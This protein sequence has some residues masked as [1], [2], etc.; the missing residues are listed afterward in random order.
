M[1]FSVY[2]LECSDRTYYTGCTNNLE[3]RIR[4]HNTSQ[5]GA[6]YTKMRRPV[7]LLYSETFATLS[8]ARKREAKIKR[9]TKK[10]KTLLMNSP[11]S[12]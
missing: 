9:L 2:I 5:K 4:E 8:E 10:K 7:I 1:K 11:L 6:R 3:K 12:P